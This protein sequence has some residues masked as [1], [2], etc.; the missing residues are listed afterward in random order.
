MQ[1]QVAVT[2]ICPKFQIIR[3][4]MCIEPTET[5]VFQ[6]KPITMSKVVCGLLL[7]YQLSITHHNILNLKMFYSLEKQALNSEKQALV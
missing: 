7:L 2:W 5:K 3:F 4:R 6:K 1:N